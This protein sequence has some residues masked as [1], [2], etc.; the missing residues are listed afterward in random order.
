MENGLSKKKTKAF[1][2]MP[3]Y[4]NET[5]LRARFRNIKLKN[6]SIYCF[7]VQLWL[8]LPK[9]IYYNKK[10]MKYICELHK[11]KQMSYTHGHLI[12]MIRER[13]I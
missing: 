1:E 5:F 12:R 2:S 11:L 10:N 13:R 7:W 9:N 8:L 3:K 4:E 6:I